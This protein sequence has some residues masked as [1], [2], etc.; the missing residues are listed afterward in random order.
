M[1]YSAYDAPNHRP[2]Y[3]SSP[4]LMLG[5]SLASHQAVECIELIDTEN[6]LTIVLLII[7]GVFEDMEGVLVPYM[8]QSSSAEWKPVHR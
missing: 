7:K 2:R 4:V 5:S 6:I 1:P 8:A 3:V